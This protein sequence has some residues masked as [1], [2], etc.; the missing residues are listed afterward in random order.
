MKKLSFVVSSALILGLIGCG[1][2]NGNTSN[3]AVNKNISSVELSKVKIGN[4]DAILSPVSSEVVSSKYV[5]AKNN[6]GIVGLQPIS[7]PEKLS[8]EYNDSDSALNSIN[9]N[10]SPYVLSSGKVIPKPIMSE[11]GN[12]ITLFNFNPKNP[13]D[14]TVSV[15]DYKSLLTMPDADA[16]LKNQQIPLTDISGDIAFFDSNGNRI[17]DIN[18]KYSDKNTSVSVTVLISNNIVKEKNLSAGTYA[19]YTVENG[20][21]VGPKDINFTQKSGSL[22][23]KVTLEKIVPFV[24]AEKKSPVLKNIT[25]NSDF[26]KTNFYIPI[27]AMKNNKVIGMGD[28]LDGVYLTESDPTNYELVS[29]V[30]KNNKLDTNDTNITLTKDNLNPDYP[31]ADEWSVNDEEYV[32]YKISAILNDELDIKPKDFDNFKSVRINFCDKSDDMNTAFCKDYNQTINNFL[33]LDTNVTL[34]DKYLINDENCSVNYSVDNSKLNI[35]IICPDGK[36]SLDI[37]NENNVTF[38][39]NYIS[40][41]TEKIDASSY[42]ENSNFTYKLIKNGNDYIVNNLN[43]K[44]SDVSWYLYDEGPQYKDKKIKKISYEGTLNYIN[45]KYVIKTN[46]NVNY[47]HTY[48]FIDSETNQTKKESFTLTFST[49]TA[50]VFDNYNGVQE[51]T[52]KYNVLISGIKTSGED[53]ITLNGKKLVVTKDKNGLYHYNMSVTGFQSYEYY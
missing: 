2:D 6:L 41:A 44:G 31:I 42:P 53:G 15:T 3:N 12:I 35:N 7:K 25:I 22:K 52:N 36:A 16:I 47:L 5:Y 40:N 24:L 32:I 23:G 43:A 17:W 20:K 21:L 50:Q 13:F 51:N 19:L 18:K 46:A 10:A 28:N 34:K 4:Q 14:V 45:G 33:S 49:K 1:N 37:T 9:K 39:V 38:D 8:G 30:L 11:D 48:S 27:I 29:Y 26:N